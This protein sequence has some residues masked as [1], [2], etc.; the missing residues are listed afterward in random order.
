MAKNKPTGNKKDAG[1]NQIKGNGKFKD[2]KLIIPPKKKTTTKKDVI[3]LDFNQLVEAVKDLAL[4]KK[5]HN[6]CHGG[7]R[8][9]FKDFVISDLR[10]RKFGTA[11]YLA[12]DGLTSPIRIENEKD[13]TRAY[14]L[15]K[16]LKEGI[17][18]KDDKTTYQYQD[19]KTDNQKEFVQHLLKEIR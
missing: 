4:Q 15:M 18:S 8:L 2:G 17:K 1:K 14:N 10:P 16:A 11:M 19:F 12:R 6:D 7:V 3:V 13:I 5:V 9:S